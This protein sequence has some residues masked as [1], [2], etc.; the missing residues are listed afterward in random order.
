MASQMSNPNQTVAERIVADLEAKD[1]LLPASTTGLA[2][3]LA[4][5]RLTSSEWIT[6]FGLDANTRKQNGKDEAQKS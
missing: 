5:G 1:I 3:K 4:S 6:L 2:A